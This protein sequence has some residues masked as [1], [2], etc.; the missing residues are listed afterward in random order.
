M[1]RTRGKILTDPVSALVLINRA[2][3]PNEGLVADALG[4]AGVAV[5]IE[6][7][8]GDAIADRARRAV[9]EGASLVIIGG[10]DGSVGAAAGALA[11][12]GTALGILPMG[13]LNHFA[14]DLGIPT[15]AGEAAR[16]IAAGRM[17]RIDVA[18]V[19]G[20]TFVNNSAIGIYPQMVLDRDGQ[21]ERLGRSKR[22]AMLVAA[23]RTLWRFHDRRL[24]LS[25]DTGAMSVDTPLLFVGN[26]DYSIAFPGAG[27]R[28]RLDDGRLCVFVLRKKSAPGLVA[29]ALRAL[30]GMTRSD[31]MVRFDAARWLRVDS[32]RPRLTV[33]AD[34]ETIELE[35]PLE[36]RIRPGALAV[37]VP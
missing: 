21:R 28:E 13:T 6:T 10:G 11:G 36:Y 25:A 30:V 20:R 16:I 1:H 22:L 33:S 15:D 7:V 34:G 17:T 27:R 19:N 4:A 9:S 24:R 14:R 32:T 23:L 29:A 12:S 37:V 3:A 8:D 5:T 2:K 18:E 35:P 31:D 26:N